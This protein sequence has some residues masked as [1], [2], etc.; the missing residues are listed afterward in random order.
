MINPFALIY[1][2]AGI[3]PAT[4]GFGALILYTHFLSPTE[5]GVY[6]VGASIAG[7][8]S[9]LFF[10]WVRLSVSRYQSKSPE[11]D[12][13]AEAIVAYGG[14]AI[15][16][17]CLTALGVLIARPNVGLGFVAASLFFSL[18]L[19]AFEISQEFKRAQLNPLRFTIIAVTRSILALAFGYA[20]I[21]LGGGGIGLLVAIGMSFLI[22]NV[23]SVS[24]GASEPLRPVSIDHLT[25]FIRYGL[26][27]SVGALAISLHGA[28]DRLGVAYMLGPSAAGYYGLAADLTRQLT[29]ILASS[30]ASAMFPIVF[31]SFAEAGIGATRERL[32][33]GAE[34]MLALVA[35]VAVWLAISADLVTGTLLGSDFR[36]GVATLL[37][38]LAIGRMC[39]ALN[40][41]Y[42]QVSFQLA[43][44]PLLQ[45][46]HDSLILVLNLALLLPLTAAFGLPG[47]A[48]A[49][50][51]AE[52]LGIMIGIWLSRRAFRLPFNGRGMARVFASTAFMA[53]ATYA[54]KLASGGHG[55]VALV[56]VLFVGGAAYLGAALLLDVAGI[57]S[58]VAAFQRSRTRSPPV[59]TLRPNL[60][61]RHEQP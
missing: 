24:R 46:A 44:K 32:K 58:S 8:V 35:P 57:R 34:L 13:R 6:V 45:V 22:A 60:A 18:S 3:V 36:V 14:T 59:L 37:P 31:R 1:L 19:T 39:G 38:V 52:A 27:F 43:E 47:T 12:L 33:E 41:Y 17:A 11:L 53:V 23:L 48:A 40:Q 54:A 56:S 30:V 49:V 55:L 5:Y 4:I 16:V 28:L 42:L 7:I 26:P 25:Q 29:A 20:A 61:Q 21:K 50:L 51:I 2:V 15:V 10:A 9:A